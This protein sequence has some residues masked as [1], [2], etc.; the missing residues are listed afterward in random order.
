MILEIVVLVLAIP[1]GFLVA[2]LANDELV[3]GRRFFIPIIIASLVLGVW[4][5]LAHQATPAL[6]CAFIL[7][8]TLVSY[9]KC[10]DKNFTKR[11][12]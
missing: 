10:F 6:T 3:A 9:V 12:V 5:A 7:I 8:M 2:Y 4:F 11:R 1:V